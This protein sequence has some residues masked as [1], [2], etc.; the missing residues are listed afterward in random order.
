METYP[1]RRD[2]PVEEGYDL[3]VAGGGP[4]GSAA[5]V[6]AA[7]LGAKVLL[8]EATGCLG[9]MGTSGLVS[10]FGPVSDGERMLVGGFMKELCEKMYERGDF[11]PHVVPD[12]LY[13][14]LNRWVPF[15][16]EALKR[17]LDDLAVQAGV[18]VRF[19][20]RVIDADADP[21]AGRVNGVI[22]S[23]IEGYRYVRAKTYVDAT[24][25]ATLSSLAGA[26][27]RVIE[28]DIKDVAPSTL[29][30]LYAGINWDHPYYGTDYRGVEAAKRE[31][32]E[33]ILQKAVDEG[34][35]SQADR[36][37]PGMNKI[38]RTTAQLNAG[39]VF[40]LNGLSCRSL[41]DGMIFARKLAVEYTEFFRKYVPGC[42]EIEHLATAPVMGVRDSRRIVGEFELT[43]EDFKSRRQFPDQVAVYNR[44]SDVHP[45]NTTK[46]EY[47]RF[48]KH[49]NHENRLGEGEC[50]GIPY[51]ILVPRGWQNLW[52]AGRCHSSDTQVHGSIRAQSAAY[53]MG[54]AS[55]TAAVQS[56]RTGQPAC[57]L[58]TEALV[59][60]LRQAG[61]YLPQKT[62]S[63]T[64][65]R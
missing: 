63:K 44:P 40:N 65:T 48:A 53:M 19:F 54:Q 2:I 12:Y 58:D 21:K 8:V 35:F 47:E 56:I 34:H 30:S 61:A 3:V 32:K 42:E 10:S 9:G 27:C 41:S 11:G 59:T 29:C 28:R 60:T 31:V 26:A 22:L 64:M 52:V 50:L 51:S 49:F 20:T 39:H 24:G 17:L 25:D 13:R 16:P 5:A 37:M 4:G 43:L 14:T 6:C 33:K 7:R 62:L 55:A 18:D 57:E 45:T 1:L 38:G 36:M 23:N 15:K 46:E